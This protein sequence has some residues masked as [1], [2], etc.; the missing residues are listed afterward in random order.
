MDKKIN[1]IRELLW[2][3]SKLRTEESKLLGKAWTLLNKLTKEISK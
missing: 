1:E 3:A 2:A